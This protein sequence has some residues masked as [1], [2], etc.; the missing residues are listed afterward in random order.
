M[1]VEKGPPINLG[2]G[3]PRGNPYDPKYRL[4]EN[5]MQE[6]EGILEGLDNIRSYEFATP[7]DVL[8]NIEYIMQ[9]IAFD[10]HAPL[11]ERNYRSLA[12]NREAL[13]R[14]GFPL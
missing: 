13:K 8:E 14:M 6:V 11:K 1:G 12:I 10:S 2:I 5:D 3:E 9:D 4:D 7:E